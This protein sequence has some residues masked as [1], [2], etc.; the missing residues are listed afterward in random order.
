MAHTESYDERIQIFRENYGNEG[1]PA[2]IL[3]D[4]AVKVG[5]VLEIMVGEQLTAKAME[6]ITGPLGYWGEDWKDAL[7]EARYGL[8]SEWRLGAPLHDMAAYAIY[9]IDLHATAADTAQISQQR[10]V[11]LLRE[12]ER[13]L[14]AVDLDAWIG[15]RDSEFSKIYGMA[16]GRFVLDHGHPVRPEDLALLGGVSPSRMRAMV[17]GDTAV[18][19]R[20]DNKRIPAT[21]ALSWLEGRETFFPSIWRD[22]RPSA[23]EIDDEH[24]EKVEDFIFIPVASDG[25][26]FT[27]DLDTGRG[28]ILGPKAD[29]RRYDNYDE[30]LAELVRMKPPRWRRPAPKSGVPSIVIGQTWERVSRSELFLKTAA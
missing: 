2:A 9:G 13:F 6:Q 28:F 17:S 16:R 7:H 12:V 8:F 30:A 27:P 18:L 21:E 5:E 24:Q 11:N 29:Q 4:V 22:Q 19:K 1:D 14:K 3:A 15:S 20:D 10:I 26:R 23:D 25:S